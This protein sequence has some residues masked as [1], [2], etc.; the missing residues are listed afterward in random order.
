MIK[1]IIHIAKAAV[2]AITALLVSSCGFESLNRVDGSGNVVTQTRN[3][4]GKITSI[5][6]GNGLEV[7]I[8]Q[9]PEISVTTEADDNLQQHIKTEVIG[10]ELKIS[11]DANIQS[12][13]KKIIIRL[14]EIESIEASGNSSVTSRNTIKTGS[15]EVSSS[16]GSNLVLNIE[17]ASITGETS[18]GGQLK[19]QGKT[20]R[21]ETKS[22]SGSN[23][24]AKTLVAKTVTAESSS[25][26]T[27]IINPL[28]SLTADAS[29][30][31][32]IFYT[33]APGSLMKETSSGGKVAQQ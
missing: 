13:S 33:N 27:T 19:L 10:N 26:S 15:I 12:G 7:I 21:L 1:I 6:A 18:S 16:S 11:A 22:S 29:S 20:D 2:A 3:I 4:T 31:G 32:R 28:E 14:P 23:L 30:G 9:A 17:A 25:G 5:S 8:E 24:N